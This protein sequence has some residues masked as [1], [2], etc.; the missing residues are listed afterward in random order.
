METLFNGSWIAIIATVSF[1]TIKGLCW[2]IIPAIV[3]KLRNGRR[4]NRKSQSV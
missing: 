4:I 1:F 3:I 2:L